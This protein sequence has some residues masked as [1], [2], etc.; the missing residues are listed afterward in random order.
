MIIIRRENLERLRDLDPEEAER[1]ATGTTQSFKRKI[2]VRLALTVQVQK[3]HP[4]FGMLLF[5]K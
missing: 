4:R 5:N 1:F 3:S 2:T